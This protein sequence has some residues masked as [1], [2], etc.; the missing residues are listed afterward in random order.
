MTIIGILYINNNKIEIS[1]KVKD[2]LDKCLQRISILPEFVEVSSSLENVPELIQG[3][4]VKR[5][6]CGRN[7]IF[8]AYSDID[9]P[10]NIIHIWTQYQR[11]FPVGSEKEGQF[12]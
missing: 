7:T 11:E 9:D 12:E 10:D 1:E 5:V 8:C 2:C 6:L 4:P 3:I